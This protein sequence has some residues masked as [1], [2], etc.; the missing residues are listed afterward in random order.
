M[1]SLGE[2]LGASAFTERFG[3]GKIYCILDVTGLA[4]VLP[5]HKGLREA[6]FAIAPD[7][8]VPC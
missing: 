6:Y 3:A 2:T 5:V 1:K 7:V 8:T 4:T